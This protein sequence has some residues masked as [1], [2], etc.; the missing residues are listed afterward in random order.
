MGRVSLLD[1]GQQQSTSKDQ[2]TTLEEG[3]SIRVLHSRSNLPEFHVK[4]IEDEDE[5]PGHNSIDLR[6][7]SRL[8][9]LDLPLMIRESEGQ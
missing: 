3:S 7:T 5:H 8:L 2:E 4:Q 6:T 9:R 1:L